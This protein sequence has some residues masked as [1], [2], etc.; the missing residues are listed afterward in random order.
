MVTGLLRRLNRTYFCGT[1]GTSVWS[2][3]A[4][5][6]A[7]PLHTSAAGSSPGRELLG[8]AWRSL[9]SDTAVLMNDRSM[10]ATGH[11]GHISMEYSRWDTAAPS[12]SHQKHWNRTMDSFRWWS[13]VQ[14][15]DCYGNNRPCLQPAN[16]SLWY[17]RPLLA[18]FD[19]SLIVL[20]RTE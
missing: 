16:F 15:L 20:T 18:V 17:F 10:A 19:F 2:C 5:L 9:H 6:S 13:E 11:A 8:T 12:Y 7:S 1:S 3:R 4:C 14:S